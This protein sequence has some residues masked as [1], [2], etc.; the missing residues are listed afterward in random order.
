MNKSKIILVD[1]QDNPITFKYREELD[2]A[3]DTY[4]CTGIWITNSKGEVLIA[5]RKHTKTKDPLKWG[6]AVSGTVEE[7]ETYE[8]NA[9]KELE[10][11]LGV[12]GAKL[13]PGPKRHMINPGGKFF[14]QWFLCAIDKPASEF[15]IQEDEVEQV[16]WIL[17][18]DLV[19]D[20]EQNPGKYVASLPDVINL[21]T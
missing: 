13:V 20:L 16:K 10:E 11:E 19:K 17:R 12:T 1:D 4:R 7:G 15:R 8:S 21:L 2:R 6:P 18:E 5:Q 3:N 9:Y 14:S